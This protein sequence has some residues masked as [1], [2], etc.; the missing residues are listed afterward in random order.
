[1]RVSALVVLAKRE[2]LRNCVIGLS[3]WFS[4][5]AHVLVS[6]LLLAVKEKIRVTVNA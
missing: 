5:G 4:T 6:F 3:L 2:M 1:M